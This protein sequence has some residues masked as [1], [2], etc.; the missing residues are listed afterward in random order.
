MGSDT[1][2]MRIRSILLIHQPW[3]FSMFWAIVRPFLR[4]KLTKRLQLLGSNLA[5]L[6]KLVP[7]AVLPAAFGGTL[8]DADEPSD[9]LIAGMRRREHEGSGSIGGWA[10]PLSVEDPTGEK[11][12][13]QAAPQ[14][15][16]A[17]DNVGLKVV[18][19]ADAL[20]D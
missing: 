20:T 1:F 9:W 3:Y 11:R 7:A 19:P 13:A 2:P 17:A 4:A 10:L 8:V 15:E 18:L 5:A 14:S 6:H 16:S 12:R